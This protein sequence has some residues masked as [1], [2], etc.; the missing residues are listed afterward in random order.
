MTGLRVIAHNNR[1]RIH[2]RPSGLRHPAISGIHTSRE[3]QREHREELDALKLGLASTGVECPR[4][5][6]APSAPCVD[7]RTKD[8]M[9]WHEVHIERAESM[10]GS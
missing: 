2:S 1:P 4:C 6:A 8:H 7:E 9:G 5:K 10:E 3:W